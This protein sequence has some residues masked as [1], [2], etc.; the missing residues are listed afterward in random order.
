MERL[1]DRGEEKLND[2]I[3]CARSHVWGFGEVKK[4]DVIWGINLYIFLVKISALRCFCRGWYGVCICVV[5]R[6]IFPVKSTLLET[7]WL[8]ELMFDFG[9]ALHRHNPAPEGGSA[10]PF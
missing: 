9:R 5:V 6:T 3:V 8:C 4:P 1:Y 2:Q 10:F 7:S